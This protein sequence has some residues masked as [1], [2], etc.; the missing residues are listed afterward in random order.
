MRRQHI[1]QTINALLSTILREQGVCESE[2]DSFLSEQYLLE[3]D[4]V[5]FDLWKDGVC[6][7]IHHLTIG[8][9]KGQSDR[10]DDK[11]VGNRE[12]IPDAGDG[13]PIHVGA[14][15]VENHGEEREQVIP[16]EVVREIPER[17]VDESQL[18][19]G[20][21]YIPLVVGDPVRQIADR[22]AAAQPMVAGGES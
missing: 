14:D 6:A 13:G 19:F 1:A 21:T 2:E 18:F 16:I 9:V 12:L 8:V 20:P 15:A 5:L 3:Q 7:V 17:V 22:L 4:L 11:I 10:G